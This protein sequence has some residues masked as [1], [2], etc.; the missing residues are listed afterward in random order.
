[1]IEGI[2]FNSLKNLKQK[3]LKID[4]KGKNNREFIIN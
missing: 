3:L 2:I 1:M 4:N